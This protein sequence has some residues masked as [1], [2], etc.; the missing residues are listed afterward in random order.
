MSDLENVNQARMR[1]MM[2]G[3]RTVLD[4]AE[5][6]LLA[7]WALL[8]AIVIDAINQRRTPFYSECERTKFKPP[9]SA[10]PVGT[11]V[12]LARFSS[13]RAFHAGGNDIWQNIGEVPKAMRGCVT[14]IVV[15]H[16][17]LQ[18]LTMHVLPMFAN[19]R[20][21]PECKPGAWDVSLLNIW[22]IFGALVWPPSISFEAKGGPNRLGNIIDRWQVGVDVG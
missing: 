5:Q 7:R 3:Q 10:F 4:P 6:K 21:L 11:S 17:I 2:R 19:R 1:T 13:F 9:L 15:G 8:K 18:T 20:I 16:L 14:N 22:P 12:W